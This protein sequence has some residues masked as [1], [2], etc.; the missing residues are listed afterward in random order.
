MTSDASDDGLAEFLGLRR[1][2]FGIAYRMLG[3]AVEAEDVVQDAWLRWQATDRSIVTNAKAFLTTVVTRLAINAASS[4]PA[5]RELY[6][7]PWLPDPID[8][9]ADPA[10]GAERGQALE[11]GV[12]LLLEKLTPTERAAYVLREAFEYSHQEIASVLEVTEPNARQLA[13]RA[14]KHIAAERREPVSFDERRHLLAAFIAAARAGDL[15]SLERLFTAQAT[16]LA[17]SN[18][19]GRAARRPVVGRE[20]VAKAVVAFSAT[21]WVGVSLTWTQANGQPAVMLSRDGSRFA[22]L[23]IEASIDGIEQLLWMMRPEKLARV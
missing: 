11:L 12:L 9:T 21:F 17:D 16:S 20:S 1:R 8:T 18:G 14:R 15:P 6:I 19:V 5:R 22:L 4:A 13:A 3:S 23:T 10:L 7:G 2:L